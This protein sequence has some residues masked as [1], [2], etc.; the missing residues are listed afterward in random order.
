[1]LSLLYHKNNRCADGPDDKTSGAVPY[2]L[3]YHSGAV[4]PLWLVEII[5]YPTYFYTT[6]LN[7]HTFEF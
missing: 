5:K 6:N 7:K 4:R 3:A 1:M 2:P